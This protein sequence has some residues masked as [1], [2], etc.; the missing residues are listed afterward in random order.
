[1]VPGGRYNTDKSKKGREPHG[2]ETGLDVARKSRFALRTAGGVVGIAVLMLV[3]VL[4]GT[5]LSLTLGLPGEV[6]SLWL[7]LGVTVLGVAL[8]LG[9]GRRSVQDATVFF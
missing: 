6:F 5:F 1:M 2:T 4:G 7:V 8:A 9:L 3:L